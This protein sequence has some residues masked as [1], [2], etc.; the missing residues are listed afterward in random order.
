MVS[1]MTYLNINTFIQ[2]QWFQGRQPIELLSHMH[3]VAMPG[4]YQFLFSN[5][6]QLPVSKITQNNRWLK[7]QSGNV[8]SISTTL[9][10]KCC[11]SV[12][13]ASTSSIIVMEGNITRLRTEWR[14][15]SIFGDIDQVRA[16]V[17]DEHTNLSGSSN[18]ARW[19]LLQNSTHLILGIFLKKGRILISWTSSVGEWSRSVGYVIFSRIGT[20]SKSFRFPVIFRRYSPHLWKDKM[21]E[22]RP[23]VYEDTNNAV[24]GVGSFPCSAKDATSSAGQGSRVQMCRLA[25]WVFPSLYSCACNIFWT[26]CLL[27]ISPNSGGKPSSSFAKPSKSS[28]IEAGALAIIRR[29]SPVGWRAAA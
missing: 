14:Y 11:I 7:T 27:N 28:F 20:R 19:E 21:A 1:G 25:N 8:I 16:K 9:N 3:V 24:W 12:Y 10:H 23:Q 2:I 4:W 13:L 26:S 5:T 22:S 29:L 6:V 17:A 15:R 18:C